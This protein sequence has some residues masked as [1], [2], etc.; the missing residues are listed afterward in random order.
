MALW[1]LERKPRILFVEDDE[2]VITMLKIFFKGMGAE[3]DTTLLGRDVFERYS[4]QTYDLIVLDIQLPDIN[5]Y[6]IAKRLRSNDLT[7]D[8]PF[9]FLTQ[10]D[11]R[12]EILYGFN[13]G[14]DDYLTKPFDIEELK[15]RIMTALR[16]KM[17]F[18]HFNDIRKEVSSGY[19]FIS[20]SH[21]DREY[22]HELLAEFEKHKVPAWIDDRIDYGTHW[23]DV[24]QKKIDSCKAVILLMS[25]NSRQSLWVKNELAYAQTKKKKILPLLLNG[26]AWL[27]VAA[28][29][30][31]DVRNQ[32][33]PS[34]NFFDTC[35]TL[36]HKK[37]NK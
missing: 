25:E 19:I 11:E 29:Q 22:A 6:E 4:P 14:C 17:H 8:I 34:K 26:E 21:T 23:P 16:H 10:K 20:Y 28:I 1:I 3:V 31:G 30:Y 7:K 24:I 32:K 36:T 18:I 5:G 12:S 37:R 9:I 15:H 13:L 2:E 35:F 33:F 27:S